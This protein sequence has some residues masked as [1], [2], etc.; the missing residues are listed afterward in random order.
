MPG[1]ETGQR[2]VARGEGTRAEVALRRSDI[3]DRIEDLTALDRRLRLAFLPA[4]LLG[5]GIAGVAHVVLGEPLIT[6]AMA[7]NTAFFFLMI[8]STRAR[9]RTDRAALREELDDLDG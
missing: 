8:Q 3:V 1:D 7:A 4:G 5:G 9:N 6:A 2:E